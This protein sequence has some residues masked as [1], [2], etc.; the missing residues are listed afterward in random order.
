MA[1]S[2]NTRYWSRAGSFAGIDDAARA[3]GRDI[4][5]MLA[6]FGFPEQALTDPELR[7]PFTSWGHMLEACAEEWNCP[8]FGLRLA[9]LQH[10]NIL[11][12]VGLAARLSDTVGGALKALEDHSVI[13]STGYDVRFDA[14]NVGS[15]TPAAVTYIPKPGTRCG[16]Q[17]LEL[18]VG[19]MRNVVA[20]VAGMPQFV[21]LRVCIATTAPAD[22]G[23]ARRYFKCPVGYGAQETA[24]QF[25]AR[26]AA[27]PTAIHDTA[28]APLIRAYLDQIGRDVDAD[29]VATTQR[30]IGQL[31]TTGR[32]SRESVAE[33]LNLHP[34]TLQRR[35]KERGT[36]FTDL[37]DDHRRQMAIDMVSRRALPLAQIADVLGFA[38]Q[39]V[40]NQA[41]RRWTDT[42][43]TRLRA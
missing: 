32:C 24:V 35:L 31:L 2:S 28:Y 38:D 10:L 14:G 41:F 3:L 37:L 21:P 30:L 23:P 1:P 36:S 18:A 16:R 4:R 25:D 19:V 39:S 29:I 43:P 40:F 5:P 26:I 34:R 33:C 6:R 22:T 7:V 17:K 27:Q 20:M 13:H 9:Q 12:P 11:G 8:D 15:S 42:T